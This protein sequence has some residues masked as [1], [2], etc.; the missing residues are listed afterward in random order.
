MR[1]REGLLT[2]REQQ[3]MDVVYARGQVAASDVE[4]A[5]PDRPSNSTVRTLLRVLEDKGWLL[6]AEQNGRY[7]YSPARPREAEG[8]SAMKRVLDTFF[9]GSVKDA[10]AGLLDEREKLS[11][12]EADALRKLIERRTR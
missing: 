5:L 3:I 1:H 6:K 11:P 2:R 8:K 7:V 9:A 4:T 12:D 10:V